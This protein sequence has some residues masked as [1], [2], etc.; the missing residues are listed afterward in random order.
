MIEGVS[1][2]LDMSPYHAK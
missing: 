1:T 2:F